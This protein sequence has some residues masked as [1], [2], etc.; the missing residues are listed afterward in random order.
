MNRE[1][2][3]EERRRDILLILAADSDYSV[4]DN[5]LQRLL[6]ER[7]LGVSLA[8]VRNDITW[9]ESKNL[10]AVQELPMCY[11][12]TARRAGVDI[13]KGLQVHPEIARLPAE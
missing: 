1:T 5:L 9:L 11:V 7:G 3:A 6:L 10:V 13:A 8:T 2:Q 12:V 4:N